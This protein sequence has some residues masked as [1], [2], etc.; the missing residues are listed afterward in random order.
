MDIYAV[1][2]FFFPSSYHPSC[3]NSLVPVDIPGLRCS[4]KEKH[5]ATESRYDLSKSSACC[6]MARMT[7]IQNSSQIPSVCF[8]QGRSEPFS[9]PPLFLLVLHEADPSVEL[10]EQT[11]LWRP[12]RP[13]SFPQTPRKASP[14]ALPG[15]PPSITPLHHIPQTPPTLP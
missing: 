11:E 7:M 12:E 10:K 13:S 1:S 9:P 14:F 5:P 6:T 2:N 4:L 8:M 3:R 15:L